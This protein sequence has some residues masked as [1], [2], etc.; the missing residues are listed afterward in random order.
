MAVTAAAGNGAQKSEA[1]PFKKKKERSPSYPPIGIGEAIRL[2]KKLYTK[3]GRTGVD[4]ATAA[5]ALEFKALS[6]PVAS[7]LSALKKYGLTVRDGDSIKLSEL[8]VRVAT[9]P[10]TSTDYTSAVKTAALKPSFIRDFL[11][12]Y[13]PMDDAVL[14]AH[15]ISQKKFSPLGAEQAIVSA[16]DTIKV[17]E[18]TESDYIPPGGDEEEDGMEGA[19]LH[20]DEKRGGAGGGALVK[21]PPLAG[22]L[23]RV[24]VSLKGG[25]LARVLFTG[26]LPTQADIQKVI[27]SLTLQ[28]D[29]FPE[30]EN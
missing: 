14:K 20:D 22:E 7:K 16:R 19:G 4:S 8:G 15:L 10:E 3:V 5:Q 18:L 9:Y 24:R 30:E 11:K 29:S 6:G 12:D 23:E 2:T 28:K 26:A 1:K 17:A 25:R 27:D 13:A 21:P